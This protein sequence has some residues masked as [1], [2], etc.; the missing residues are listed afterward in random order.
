MFMGCQVP[1]RVSVFFSSAF[2]IVPETEDGAIEEH[3][4]GLIR[5]KVSI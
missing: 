5:G 2:I 1:L 4:S 3:Q